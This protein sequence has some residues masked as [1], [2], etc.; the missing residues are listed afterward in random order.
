MFTHSLVGH[1]RAVAAASFGLVIRKLND[2]LSTIADIPYK[3]GRVRSLTSNASNTRTHFDIKQLLNQV[4]ITAMAL[5]FAQ[6]LLGL[7]HPRPGV[8]HARVAWEHAHAILGRAA[9]SIGIVNVFTGLF[10]AKDFSVISSDEFNVWAGWSAA[11][12]AFIWVLGAVVLKAADQKERSRAAS[13]VGSEPAVP[14]D[15]DKAGLGWKGTSSRV[16][17]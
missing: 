5:L 10:L 8:T 7:V 6:F 11:S 17:P 2:S 1:A 4:G 9:L 3:H 16:A 14:S 15:D 13:L 12:V